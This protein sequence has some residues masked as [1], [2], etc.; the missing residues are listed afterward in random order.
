[1]SDPVK[2][3][4]VGTLHRLADHRPEPDPEPRPVLEGVVLDKIDMAP[5]PPRLRRVRRFVADDRTKTGARLAVRHGSY[6]VGGT[7]IVAKRA[8]DGRSAARY[9]RMIRAAEAAGD[10]E[11]AA[12][13]EEKGTAFRAARHQRRMDLLKAPQQVVK[14]AAVGVAGTAGGLLGLGTVLA[15]A[16]K[17]ITQV[18]VPMAVTIDAIQTVVWLASVAWGPLMFLGPW[19]GLLTLWNL[20]RRGQAAP[21][22]TLPTAEQDKRDVVPDEGAILDALRHLGIGPLNQAFKTGWQPRWM[23]PT[24]RLGNGWHTQVQLPQGVTVEMLNKKKDVLASNLLRLPVEVWP[25]EPTT[26]PGTLDLWVAD[27]G[28]LSGPV[29]PWPLLTDGTADYFKGVPVGISQRGEPV[30]AKLMAANYLVGG[31]M[32]S[33]KS[34]LIVSLLLGAMLDPLV[35]ADVYVMA[36]NVDYDP[37]KDR[38]RTLVKGDDDEQVEAALEALRGL[39]D[40]VSARGKLLEELGGDSAKLTRELAERDPRMRPRVVVFDECHELF[41][42]K[43]YGEEAAEL[44]I[45]VMKKARKIGITLVFVTVSPTATSIPKE[46][47][48]NTSHNVAFAV[49]DFIANDGLLG[50][51]KYKTGI[52]ATTLNPAENVGTCLT[53]GFTANS[54]ELVRCHYVKKDAATDEI[55]PVVKRAMALRDGITPAATPAVAEKADHLA[56]IRK[57]MGDADKMRTDEVRQRLTERNPAEYRSWTAQDL[58]AALTEAGAPPRKSNG[59]RVVDRDMVLKAL[60]ERDSDAEEA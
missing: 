18:I 4:P 14:A 50:S 6:V 11:E 34:S 2:E 31:I 49:G 54:F 35:E 30:V 56:D 42:H 59:V 12:L 1:M 55:T 32:G 28:S 36:Y 38:L 10:R 47:T 26:M 43:K 58:T 27:Q 48:R 40:E 24:T 60:A 46:L 39:R 17:D 53:V 9:E 19:L 23:Q 33:G 7:R 8:W 5:K 25:T 3:T 45:K 57:V 13:W 20:G 21:N 15:I 41:E 16:E 52:T 44:A 51:G 22:W 29:P 37:M